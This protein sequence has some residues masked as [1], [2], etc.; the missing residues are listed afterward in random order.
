MKTIIDKFSMSSY[1]RL[2]VTLSNGQALTLMVDADT[3]KVRILSDSPHV[4]GTQ[5]TGD[6]GLPV[7]VVYV[8]YYGYPID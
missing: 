6:S 5:A 7:N 3:G 2:E 4:I 8:D 1:Q